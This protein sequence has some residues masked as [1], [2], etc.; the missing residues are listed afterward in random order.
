[1]TVTP[2]AAVDWTWFVA[3]LHPRARQEARPVGRQAGGKGVNVSRVLAALGVPVRSVVIV[4]GSAGAEIVRDLECTGLE[5]VVVAAGGESRTCLEIVDERSC[6]ATQLHG[7]GVE[8]DA[9]TARALVAAVGGALEGAAWL[10]L[11]GS[12]PPG[13][14]TDA[15]ATLI[16]VARA[17]GVRVAVDASGAALQA[18]WHARPDLLR[19]N[20]NEASDLPDAA[21]AGAAFGAVSDG[22][23]EI[24]AWEPGRAWR[25]A[26]PRARVRNPIGC[27][28][29]MLAGLL[30]R[31]DAGPFEAA[32]R[33]ATALATAEAESPVAGR[34][35]LA[36]AER[37]A[38]DVA[39]REASA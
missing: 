1:V 14:P 29:A 18:A 27:G 25:V 38:A 4:G 36:L 9:A 15:Y 24:A 20:R 31:I 30:A 28:D 32:L 13:L 6:A 34:P 19:I 11:C 35:D 23:R 10:A 16:D 37:R 8:A 39:L 33:F 2:N 26:P 12:L 21:A 7:R 3:E 5:P 22:P 17:R